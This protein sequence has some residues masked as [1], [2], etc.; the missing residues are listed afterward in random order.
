[1]GQ[2]S[3]NDAGQKI[4]DICD[5]LF[6]KTKKDAQNI[7]REATDKLYLEVRKNVSMPFHAK[8]ELLALGSPFAQKHGTILPHGHMPLWSIHIEYGDILKGLDKKV[9]EENNQIVGYI[10][11]FNPDTITI[12][13]VNKMGTGKMIGRPVLNL[14]AIDIDL[15]GFIE[16]KLREVNK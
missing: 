14:T 1:M 15:N 10:G 12:Y 6:A 5:R 2:Y 13:V 8:K 4:K 11:W 7:V 9:V 16:L 3:N